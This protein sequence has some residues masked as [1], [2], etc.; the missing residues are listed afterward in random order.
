MTESSL[1]GI[2]RFGSSADWI[3]PDVLHEMYYEYSSGFEIASYV[4][5]SPA[6]V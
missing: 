4:L 3:Q 6:K 2:N 5:G 1:D